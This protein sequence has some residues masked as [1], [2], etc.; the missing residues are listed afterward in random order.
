MTEWFA[1]ATALLLSGQPAARLECRP[2]VI[3]I[4]SPGRT[5]TANYY[6]QGRDSIAVLHPRHRLLAERRAGQFGRI[7]YSLLAY[8]AEPA[9]PVTIGAFAV[10]WEARRSWSIESSCRAA[11]WTG[12]LVDAMAALGA[13]PNQQSVSPDDAL[14]EAVRSTAARE[15]EPA[16]PVTSFEGWLAGVLGPQVRIQWEVNDCG[17]QTGNPALDRGRDF[18]KCVQLRAPLSGGRSVILMLSTGSQQRRPAGV[19]GF[20]LGVIML[21]DDGQVEIRR[22]ADLPLAVDGR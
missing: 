19:P 2:A 21:P 11:G 9:G 3:E 1:L 13:L 16:L 15:I 6:D 18:P 4:A 5:A 8:Q 22:L 7:E 17:E 10:D 14:I 20:H 12:G